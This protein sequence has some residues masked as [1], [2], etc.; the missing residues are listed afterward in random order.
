MAIVICLAGS[1]TMIAQ[2]E[3]G[4][5]IGETTWATRN[6]GSPGTFVE[7][8]EDR[9][10]LYQWNSKLGW[11]NAD[12][13]EPSDGTSVWNG[14][15]DGGGAESWERANDPCPCGWRVPTEEECEELITEDWEWLGNGIRL[16]SEDNFIFLPTVTRR[17]GI[18]GALSGTS[19]SVGDYWSGSD[20]T[21]NSGFGFYFGNY[22]PATEP[23]YPYREAL[24][25][26]CVKDETIG[27][28]PILRDAE[29]ATVTGY[30]DIS[31]RKLKAEPTKGLYII[32]YDN[33]T[34][35]KVMR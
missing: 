34:A 19:L 17:G 9:G 7:N 28:N 27:I 18:D 5:K 14:N 8:P 16:G 12:P 13:L 10:M 3:T 26:R 1:A 4:V 11:S 32:Q 31:G 2:E 23:N 30:F 6:V 29:N 21:G 35:K 15:W 33:G 22:R 25:I 24:S 20:I